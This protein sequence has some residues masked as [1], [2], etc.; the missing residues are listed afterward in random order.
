MALLDRWITIVEGDSS[1]GRWYSLAD[2]RK[3]EMKTLGRA[4]TRS[5]ASF[6]QR[7]CQ[8]ASQKG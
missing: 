4:A 1:I 3:H 2:P 5:S 6:H 8:W 7:S